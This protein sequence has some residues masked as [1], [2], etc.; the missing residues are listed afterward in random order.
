ML[1]L[2]LFSRY[3]FFSYLRELFDAPD[4]VMSYLCSQ[5]R[6]HDVPVGTEKTRNMIERVRCPEYHKCILFWK[7]YGKLMCRKQKIA[8]AFYLAFRSENSSLYT[9]ILQGILTNPISLVQ[10]FTE[11][12]LAPAYCS[13]SVYEVVLS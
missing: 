10:Y 8:L 1:F 13:K 4:P 3:G 11:V 6:V 5:Y 12:Y 7:F 9:N 2:I